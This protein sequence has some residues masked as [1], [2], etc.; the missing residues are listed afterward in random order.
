[1]DTAQND[2]PIKEEP[3]SKTNTPVEEKVEPGNSNESAVTESNDM[4][5][6]VN[7][8]STYP[9]TES[10]SMDDPSTVEALS[11]PDSKVEDSMSKVLDTKVDSV[12]S[13]TDESSVDS[14]V[15]TVEPEIVEKDEPSEFKEVSSIVP[16]EASKDNITQEFSNVETD[17][18]STSSETPL[19][20]SN[21]D[22]IDSF[23][24]PTEVAAP[25][26]S[27]IPL[28]VFAL[29]IVLVA[30]AAYLFLFVLNKSPKTDVPVV[31]T[32]TKSEDLI[33]SVTPTPLPSLTN[34][35]TMTPTPLP[36]EGETGVMDDSMQG[37]NDVFKDLN[38]KNTTPTVT[39]TDVMT[40]TP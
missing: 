24:K 37:P 6:A 27:K 29:V 40:T 34:E 39:P 15:G 20:Q 18:V 12:K 7:E 22:T 26:K 19:M 1:M 2:T 28:Y 16:D 9:T 33:P 10:S 31:V 23:V 30:A 14:P 8:V 4:E 25:G 11:E 36:T 5:N 21:A 17:S 32:P 35:D 38:E 13:S 3:S